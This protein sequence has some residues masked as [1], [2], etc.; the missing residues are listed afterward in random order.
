MGMPA[1]QTEW[2]AEMERALP[3]DRKRYEVLD[4]ELFV[5]EVFG[6]VAE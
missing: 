3:D 2:T 4:G 1:P 6:P 5:K